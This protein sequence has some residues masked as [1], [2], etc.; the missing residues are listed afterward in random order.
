MYRENVGP[1]PP[2]PYEPGRQNARNCGLTQLGLAAMNLLSL[3]GL[4]VQMGT[5]KLPPELHLDPAG[6]SAFR[7][8]IVYGLMGYVLVMATWAALNYWGLNRR[9]KLAYVS[10][11]GFAFVSIFSC[12]SALF[13]GALL[14]LLFKREMKGY[15]DARPSS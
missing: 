6:V 3:G 15:F 7:H 13:G 4:S 11:I 14:Y 2:D 1:P 5:M 9:S 12:F 10:S 8:G